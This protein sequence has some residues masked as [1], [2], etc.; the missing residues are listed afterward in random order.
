[1]NVLLKD[2]LWLIENGL[3]LVEFLPVVMKR[4][5]EIEE[6]EWIQ[7]GLIYIELL[8]PKNWEQRRAVQSFIMLLCRK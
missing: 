1:M 8:E 3:V 7:S 5:E 2:Q 4:Y 6:P